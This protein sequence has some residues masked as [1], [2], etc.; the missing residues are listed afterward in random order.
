MRTALVSLVLGLYA[1]AVIAQVAHA[2]DQFAGSD[3]WFT[4]EV[5]LGKL[6]QNHCDIWLVFGAERNKQATT[7]FV[8][9]D[10]LSVPQPFS[11]SKPLGL[12]DEVTLQ[13]AVGDT[14]VS[15]Q[16]FH[17]LT[18]DKKLI[19]KGYSPTKT[20]IKPG[21]DIYQSFFYALPTGTLRRLGASGSTK[22]RA[23]G[24]Q[25]TCDAVVDERGQRAIAA[26]LATVDS[27][28]PT[29]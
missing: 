2:T 29:R 15:G 21:G 16:L 24:P 28:A 13:F 10:Y 22:I 19:V 17:P 23:Q 1:P 27:A 5:G 3:A 12:V 25:R 18:A 8:R 4:K 26:L 9:V 7:E 11:S 14:L 20:D 6:E